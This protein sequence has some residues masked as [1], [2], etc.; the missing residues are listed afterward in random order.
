MHEDFQQAV[1]IIHHLQV[2]NDTA[3][4]GFKL[5]EEY[6]SILTKNEDQKQFVSQV[7][8]DYRYLFPDCEKETLKSYIL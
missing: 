8:K 6:N 4:R 5:M 2:V 1:E 7:V 3:E